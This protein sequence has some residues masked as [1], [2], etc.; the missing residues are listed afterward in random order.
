M[1][2]LCRMKRMLSKTLFLLMIFV[3]ACSG[4]E[5]KQ[6]PKTEGTPVYTMKGLEGDWLVKDY[7]D[8]LHSVNYTGSLSTAGYGIT[9][10]VVPGK[11]D[12]LWIINEG[13]DRSIL[14]VTLCGNDSVMVKTA[15]N[16]GWCI[17]LDKKTSRLVLAEPSGKLRNGYFRVPDSL[18]TE[19]TPGSAFRNALQAAFAGRYLVYGTGKAAA[20]ARQVQFHANGTVTGLNA[21]TYRI[22]VAGDEANIRDADRLDLSDGKRVHSY[23]MTRFRNGWFLYDLVPAQT[24]QGKPEFSKGRLVM[25]MHFE[26][27]LVQ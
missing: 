17:F 5:K 6:E 26:G 2:Y 15:A 21:K 22:I 1:D 27:K 12:S 16:G 20:K 19:G 9:E 25:E 10:I 18:R 4:P 14:P 3:A 13:V 11:G 7:F 24:N 23:G 8:K